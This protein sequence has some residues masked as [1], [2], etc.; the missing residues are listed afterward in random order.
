MKG[1]ID[2]DNL[3][4][5]SLDIARELEGQTHLRGKDRLDLLQKTLRFALKDSDKSVLEKEQVLH[6]IDTVLPVAMQAAILAT[7]SPIQLPLP[8]C[9]KK[10]VS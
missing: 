3:V 7:K 10:C 9:W 8:T 2:W 5:I 6:T 4:P 1:R